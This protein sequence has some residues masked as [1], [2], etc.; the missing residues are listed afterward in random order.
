M[1]RRGRIH[2]IP[3]EIPTSLEWP[4]FSRGSIIDSSTILPSFVDDSMRHVSIHGAKNPKERR[5]RPNTDRKED[6]NEQSLEGEARRAEEWKGVVGSGM[7][8]ANAPGAYARGCG[9]VRCVSGRN[10][11]GGRDMAVKER[12]KSVAS[13][14][15]ASWR[16]EERRGE[17]RAGEGR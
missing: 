2:G 8:F 10:A 12:R 15:G 5:R 13:T 17:R 4:R 1:A 11:R 6:N 9:G 14:K 7:K 16:G 3:R